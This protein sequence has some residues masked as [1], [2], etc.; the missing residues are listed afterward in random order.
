MLAKKESENFEKDLRELSHIMEK[1]KK[2]LDYIKLTEKNRGDDTKI[3]GDNMDSDKI[4]GQRGGNNNMMIS[5]NNM[6][7][8]LNNNNNNNNQKLYKDRNINQAML[9]KIQ[10]YEEDFAKI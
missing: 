1:N 10:K 3:V 6:N 8:N 4:G 2:A 9:D 7:N 5:A